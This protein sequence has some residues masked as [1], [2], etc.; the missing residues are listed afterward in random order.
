MIKR[1]MIV[2][3][4]FLS[5]AGALIAQNK[6]GYPD[7]PV[8][9]PYLGVPGRIVKYNNFNYLII[10]DSSGEH[11]RQST[12]NYWEV[13]YVY[14]SLFRQK[15]KFRDFAIQQIK[16][17][18]GILFFQDTL[19]L[20]FGIRKPGGNLWGRFVFLNDRVY[21][22]RLIKET[23]FI[24]RLK[25]DTLQ[26]VRYDIAIPPVD[27]PQRINFLPNS[28]IK[29]VTESKYNHYTFT[30]DVKDTLYTQVVM[31]PYWD[32]KLQVQRPDGK[33]DKKVSTVEVLESY[34][35]SVLKAG[36]KIVKSRPR[37]LVFTLPVKQSTLWCRIMSSI[38][39]TYFMKVLIQ[40]P[41]DQ[42]PLKK[43]VL[44]YRAMSDSSKRGIR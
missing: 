19:Q 43:K 18:H 7:V 8:F 42:L 16:K 41:E 37:E 44:T 15:K 2:G 39:G 40:S 25:L 3:L 31:G 21:R 4:F 29:R 38:D 34:Y 23:V 35:R 22:L 13:S 28:V 10:P 6:S 1:W 5:G 32:L 24:N 27:L 12:G 14:D 17:N 33:V 26:D 36:G 11:T 20:N 9:K 30:Y